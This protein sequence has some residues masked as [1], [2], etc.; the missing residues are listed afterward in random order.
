MKLY[1]RTLNG[2]VSTAGKSPEAPLQPRKPAF[3]IGCKIKR[4]GNAGFC[5]SYSL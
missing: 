4:A 3:A 5:K 1:I 2:L